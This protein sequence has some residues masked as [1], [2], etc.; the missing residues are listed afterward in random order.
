MQNHPR[1]ISVAEV[2]LN[3]LSLRN[4]CLRWSLAPWGAGLHQARSL[5][6]TAP[7]QL[8]KYPGRLPSS[9][10]ANRGSLDRVRNNL[11]SVWAHALEGIN[12][13]RLSN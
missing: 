4:A 9:R 5:A 11:C 1:L 8:G 12:P 7:Q 6:G 2:S 10:M 3:T 13:L